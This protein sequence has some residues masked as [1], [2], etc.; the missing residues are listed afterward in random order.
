M[1]Y[2]AI[3][4]NLLKHLC[5]LVAP[6]S[7]EIDLGIDVGGTNTRIGKISSKREVF[8]SQMLKTSQ[9][10][11]QLLFL[12]SMIQ[13][14]NNMLGDNRDSFLVIRMGAS[15]VNEQNQVIVYAA[16]LYWKSGLDIINVLRE[17]I[18]V[19]VKLS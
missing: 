19:L 7:T 9:L 13:L 5:Y 8:E 15:S 14:T 2:P 16:N 17:I 11:M 18:S 4:C 6:Y 1:L 10:E 12:A 3:Y